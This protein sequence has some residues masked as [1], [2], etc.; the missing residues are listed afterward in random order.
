[1]ALTGLL[2]L[3]SGFCLVTLASI[4]AIKHRMRGLFYGWKMVGVSVLV[5]SL[6]SGSLLSGVGVWVKVLEEQFPWSRTQLTGAFSLTQLQSGAI[7]PIIGYFI[8]RLGPRRMVLIGLALTGLGFVV[9]SRTTNLATFY[10]AFTLIMLGATAGTWL[11]FMTLANRWFNRKR[12]TAMAVSGEGHFIGGFLLI[13]VLAWA[14]SPGSYGW[15][16]TALWIGVL[17]LVVAWPI[18]RSIRDRPE[19][20]GQHPDGDLLSDTQQAGPQ[21]ANL[22]Q[23]QR[24][25][26][27]SPNRDRLASDQLDFTAHEAIRTSAFWYI[28]FGHALSSMLFST[29]K[30]HLVLLMTDQGLSLQSAAYMWSVLMVSGAVFLPVGGYIGDRL[31]KTLAI[32]GFVS[33][34]AIGFLLTAFAQSMPIA[35]LAVVLY[36][37]G[38]GGRDPLTSSIRGDYFGRSAFATITGISMMP[39]FAVN[40]AAPLFA[41]IMFDTQGSYTIAFVILGSLGA[42]SGVLFLFAKKP[43]TIGS[44]R[45]LGPV[46]SPA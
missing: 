35:I 8:D 36:G 40:L 14:V 34:Q 38:F 33:L 6:V 7:G 21:Q 18:S 15:S 32:F 23:E 1:M 44:P 27:N 16:T 25:A 4:P 9:F 24:Q 22:P 31:P 12:T 3:T 37:A 19:D 46:N 17:L 26:Y 43:K 13:P 41:A 10:L 2:I 11:P 42:L 29:L 28:T 5:G 20:Y 30:V 39:L 45:G